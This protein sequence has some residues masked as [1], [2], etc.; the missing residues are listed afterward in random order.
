MGTGNQRQGRG[1]PLTEAFRRSAKLLP[2]RSEAAIG[3]L[4]YNVLRKSG[5]NLW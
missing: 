4:Y 1:L 3:M 5:K 2:H